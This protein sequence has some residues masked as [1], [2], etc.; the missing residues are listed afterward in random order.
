MGA[1]VTLPTVNQVRRQVRMSDGSFRFEITTSVTDEGDL[2]YRQLFVATITDPLNEKADVLARLATPLDLRADSAA[3]Y[4]RVESSDLRIIA[5]DPFLRVANTSDLTSLPRDRAT[6]VSRGGTTYL[7]STVTILYTTQVTAQAAY[8]TLLDRLSQL[9]VDWRAYNADFLTV[10]SQNYTLP[11]VGASVES[12]YTA[13]Y[14]TAKTAT[15]VARAARE[16]AQAAV[17]ACGLQDALLDSVLDILLADVAFLEYAKTAISALAG[18]A[19]TYA[20]NGADP[21]SYESMLVAKRAKLAQQQ[22][23]VRT[24]RSTC[25][26]LARTL[27]T[28]E[29]VLQNAEAAERTALTDLLRVCPTF[30]PNSVQV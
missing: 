22:T 17:D 21:T 10:P 12:E 19:R 4:V 25:T 23:A 15:G 14:T 29:T 1:S 13:L 8:K 5:G 18:T 9:V 3:V 24:H 20:L 30:D 7:T 2:P 27:Q 26:G 6:A 11:L 16:T 28:A